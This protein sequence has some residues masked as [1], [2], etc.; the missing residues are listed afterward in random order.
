MSKNKVQNETSR[1]YAA[2]L[3]FQFN[4]AGSKSKR[5]PCEQRIVHIEA[6]SGK[7]ALGIA[8]RI[9]GKAQHRY[10][11]TDGKQVRFEFIGVQD[12]IGIG[13]ECEPN[14]VW[15]ELVKLTSPMARKEKYIP[16]E[17]ELP[18]IMYDV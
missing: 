9:G 1:L 17:N 13:S 16:P 14:E 6:A 4:V 3:L 11:N 12:L 15:Y 8:K 18:A 2:K 5:V 10:K 7:K